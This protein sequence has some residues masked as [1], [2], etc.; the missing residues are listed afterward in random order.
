MRHTE[1]SSPSLLSS[2]EYCFSWT[3]WNK[4]QYEGQKWCLKLWDELS[5]TTSTS[6]M[7]SKGRTDLYEKQCC[8]AVGVGIGWMA[9]QGPFLL[10]FFWR[11]LPGPAG[12]LCKPSTAKAG[13]VHPLLCWE[14]LSWNI[15][16]LQVSA[17]GKARKGVVRIQQ[18]VQKTLPNK[19]GL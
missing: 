2:L 16:S 12:S 14:R 5:W 8:D 13:F 18:K 4:I 3:A 19:A 9:F 11:T 10:C 17:H 1:S 7:L 6:W 15:P